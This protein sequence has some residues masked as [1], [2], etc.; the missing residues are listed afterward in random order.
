MT[1][2]D[3]GKIVLHVDA[4]QS[5]ILR[6]SKLVCKLDLDTIWEKHDIHE[7]FFNNPSSAQ[8]EF[9]SQYKAVRYLSELKDQLDNIICV[10]HLCAND[11]DNID[12]DFELSQLRKFVEEKSA[13]N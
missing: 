2:S 11:D 9:N 8:D 7:P 3:A 10:L 6:F 12:Y 4:L 1:V 13:N 5:V